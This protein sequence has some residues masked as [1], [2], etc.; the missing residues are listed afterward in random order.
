[1]D[2]FT[3]FINTE[4]GLQFVLQLSGAVTAIGV[5]TYLILTLAVDCIGNIIM[6]TGRYLYTHTRYYKKKH[7]KALAIY[8]ACE[9]TVQQLWSEDMIDHDQY[10][11]FLDSLEEYRS[12]H[13]GGAG[14]DGKKNML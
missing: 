5:G 12:R 9:T 10:M 13:T 11:T 2:E 7:E 3:R 14:Q 1:M 8:D 6:E 4:Q